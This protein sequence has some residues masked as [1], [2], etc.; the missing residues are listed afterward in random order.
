LTAASLFSWDPFGMRSLLE[1]EPVITSKIILCYVLGTQGHIWFTV[2]HALLRNHP[3]LQE[4]LPG[5]IF[6][7][8]AYILYPIS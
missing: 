2:A 8:L 1:H 4:N 6:L 5:S 3:S 7:L